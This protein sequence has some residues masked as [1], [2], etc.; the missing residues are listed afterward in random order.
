MKSM[1]STNEFLEYLNQH[2]NEKID[3]SSR[4]ISG[5]GV[6]SKYEYII[7]TEV[8]VFTFIK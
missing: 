4:R 3:I 8:G 7:R 2:L 6:T 1:W 5:S